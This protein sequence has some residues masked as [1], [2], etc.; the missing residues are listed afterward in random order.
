MVSI[1]EWMLNSRFPLI[2]VV[3]RLKCV[4]KRALS[5]AETRHIEST[6]E[7]LRDHFKEW[8]TEP[9][10]EWHLVDFAFYEGCGG[11]EHCGELLRTAAPLALG[12]QLVTKHDF[13]WCM[14]S[15]DESQ[16]WRYAIIHRKL[17][18]PIDLYMLDEQPLLDR[19]EHDD[20]TEPF[21]PGEGAHESLYAIKRMIE[22]HG[23]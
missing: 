22:Q 19:D 8:P 23:G 1:H 16:D 2:R 9:G 17:D 5:P 10:N 18:E 21:Y 6:L 12:R 20:D 14:Y 3:T 7:Q 4:M 11:S 15:K 13:E